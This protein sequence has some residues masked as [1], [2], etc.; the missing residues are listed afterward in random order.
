[1]CLSL[2][3]LWILLTNATVIFNAEKTPHKIFL[4]LLKNKKRL[5]HNATR[6]LT[7]GAFMQ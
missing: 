6:L 5:L 2:L 3:N 1:M 4:L 7:E